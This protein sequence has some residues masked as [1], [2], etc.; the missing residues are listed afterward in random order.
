MVRDAGANVGVESESFANGYV[1]T[2]EAPTLRGSYG[3]LQK[4][5]GAPQGLPGTF[6][7]ARAVA[8]QVNL[9]ADIDSFN[10]ERGAGLLQDVQSGR[11]NFRANSVAVRNGNRYRFRH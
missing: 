1:E 8:C 2:F 6:L 11:H 5:F 7:N 9:F 10:L 4:N 3:R